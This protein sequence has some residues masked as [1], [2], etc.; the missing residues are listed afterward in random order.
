MGRRPIG[1][2]AMTNTERSRRWREL[3][4]KARAPRNETIE[5]LQ[6]QLRERDAEIARLNAA[7]LLDEKQLRDHIRVMDTVGLHQHR[8][9]TDIGTHRL[10]RR[11]LHPDSRKSLRD[12]LLHKAWLAFQTLELVTYDKKASRPLPMD[13]DGWVRA[14][15][16]AEARKREERAR[17]RASRSK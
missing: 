16:E 12:E 3:H 11:C 17:K 1:E 6:V 8:L 7:R 10:F 5:A 15:E 2:A 13:L 4:G 9:I 14:K